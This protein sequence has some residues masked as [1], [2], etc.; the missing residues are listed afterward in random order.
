VVVLVNN[1][2]F[3][4]LR[5]VDVTMFY[6]TESGGVRTYLTAKANWLAR[7]TRV[8]HIVVAPDLIDS[9]GGARFVGVPSVPIPYARG[10]RM[11]LSCRVAAHKIAELRP[12]FIEVGD[13][14]QL[15]W[16]ALRV[17]TRADVP[18][19]AFCHS[20]L[21]RLVAHRFGPNAQ[22]IA[23]RHMRSLYRRFDLVL[24]PSCSM[25]EQLIDIGVPKV[26][27]Q[28]LGVDTTIFHPA[29]RK[30]CLRKQLGL[31]EDSR[32]LIYAGRFTNEKK[33]PVLIEAVRQLGHP[34]HLLLVGCGGRLPPAPHVTC[35]SFRRNT[36]ELA[37][38]IA[39]CDA[40]VHAGDQETFGLVVLEAMACGLP[41]IGVDAGGV[42]ELVDQ[43]TGILVERNNAAAFAEGIQHV[44]ER[45][46]GILGANARRKAVHTYDWNCI[47]PQLMHQYTSLFASPWHVDFGIG[48]ACVSE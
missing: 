11:P 24:A 42:S 48:G 29:R 46:I 32:L 13:P 34:Y 8:E 44:Y 21:P 3:Q 36:V 30:N 9:R 14:Y 7:Q 18:V 15:A 23:K 35:L 16:A 41:V 45:G 19:V 20:D 6:T 4:K 12:D 25:V 22:G 17:K 47:I 2:L 43:E 40:L 10:Y 33:L 28:P 31:P 26:S 5:F 38:L 27:H 1:F 37:E 39:S